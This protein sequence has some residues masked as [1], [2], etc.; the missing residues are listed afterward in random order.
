MNHFK[1]FLLFFGLSI[2]NFLYSQQKPVITGR[3]T[4][5][6]SGEPLSRTTIYIHEARTGAIS[7]DNGNYKTALIAR[8]TYLV[9]ISHTGY[10]SLLETIT[11]DGLLQKDFNR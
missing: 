7:D 4:D 6:K 3:I 2:C 10:E 1:I 5:A 11:I 8:G 9:E